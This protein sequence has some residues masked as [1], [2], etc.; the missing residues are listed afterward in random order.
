MRAAFRQRAASFFLALAAAAAGRVAAADTPRAEH[1]V[2]WQPRVF[3]VRGAGEIEI[4]APV[5]RLQ[6][7]AGPEGRVTVSALLRTTARDPELARAA[8][9]ASSIYATAEA[10][11]ISIDEEVSDPPKGSTTC[12]LY[13]EVPPRAQV[14]VRGGRV[15]I[16]AQR[17]AGPLD[18]TSKSG[19]VQVTLAG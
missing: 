4:H 10:D 14:R 8:S 11:K 5:G 19:S 3:P 12:E 7:V 9:R 16:D 6:I 18:V 15:A 13:V 1:L 2:E 17:L